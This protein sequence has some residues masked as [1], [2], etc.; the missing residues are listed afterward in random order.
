MRCSR[1]P[2][3][4]RPRACTKIDV[5]GAG[6]CA[7]VLRERLQEGGR[8]L[9]LHVHADCPRVC[10]RQ[11]KPARRYP[12][13]ARAP[14]L[15]MHR[16]LLCR[17]KVVIHQQAR[18]ACRRT[19]E[20]GSQLVRSVGGENAVSR[21]RRFQAIEHLVQKRSSCEISS[22][23]SPTGFFRSD[24]PSDAVCRCLDYAHR[25]QHELVSAQPMTILTIS[26][27]I[28]NPRNTL[29]YPVIASRT[30]PYGVRPVTS[31]GGSGY[32]PTRSSP[33]AAHVHGVDVLAGISG[34]SG[35]AGCWIEK[36][37]V[38]VRGVD[39][40]ER[41]ADSVT[42]RID[43]QS[44]APSRSCSSGPR[45][46][47]ALEFAFRLSVQL[48]NELVLDKVIPAMN[49]QASVLTTVTAY[50]S[51]IANRSISQQLYSVFPTPRGQS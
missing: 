34:M 30:A 6:Q 40:E 38:I 4:H 10:A 51:V 5:H 33:I 12:V 14:E 43:R 36:R 8:F 41:E 9:L 2:L 21:K 11:E 22:F 50:Q 37:L 49:R 46:T 25:L 47:S 29:R 3:R 23:T 32:S 42:S 18:S 31:K 28:S 7:R 1:T 26:V 16:F 45:W 13:T 48:V 20:S 27:A 17:P 15:N 44:S 39:V 24:C 19:S 35:L